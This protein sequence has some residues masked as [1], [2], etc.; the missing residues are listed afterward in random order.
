MGEDEG[1]CVG[2]RAVTLY[3]GYEI[4][5]A[6]LSKNQYAPFSE[7]LCEVINGANGS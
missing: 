2:I 4:D 6:H 3:F 1:N 5:L 7:V